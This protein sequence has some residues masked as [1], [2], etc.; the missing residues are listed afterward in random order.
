MCGIAGVL[1]EV[2]ARPPGN[3]ELRRMAM[4]IRHRGPDGFGSYVDDQVG[5]VHA[6]LAV[7]DVEGGAQPLSNEDGS[8]WI[9]FNG[10]IFNYLELRRE[11][12]ACGHRFRTRSDTEVIVHA[13]EEWGAQA[14]TKMNGQFAFALCDRR[15]HE[16]WLVRDRVGIAPLFF[17]RAAGAV[18][19]GSEVKAILASGLVLPA[20]ND[21]ALVEVFRYWSTPGPE[22]VFAGVQQVPP[23]CAVHFDD[24]LR[25]RQ[26]RYFSQRFDTSGPNSRLTIAEASEVLGHL[27]RDAVRIRLRADVPVGAYLSGGLDSS[28]V[29]QLVRQLDTSRLQTFSVR[30]ADARYDEGAAQERIARI[31]G[32]SHH[33]ILATAEILATELPN[34]IEHCET[35]LLRT[36]PIPMFVLSVLVRKLGMR[37]VLTGEGADEFLGGYDLFKEDGVR[38]FWARDPL[39]RTRP[40]LLTRI[41]PYIESS[42]KDGMWQAFFARG[43]TDVDDPF[44]SHRPRWET[45]GWTTRFISRDVRASLD[46][47]AAI[48]RLEAA[49]PEGWRES[50]ALERAQHIEIATFMSPYLLASQGDRALM[51]HGVEGRFPFLDPQVIEFVST[52]A[53]RHKLRGLHDKIVLRRLARQWLPDEI[54]SRPKWPYR[55]PIMQAFV[56]QSAPAYVRELMS[57]NALKSNPLLDSGAATALATRAFAQSHSMSEREEMA[58]VGVLTTQIWYRAFIDPGLCANGEHARVPATPEYASRVVAVD[59]RSS[60]SKN[61]AAPA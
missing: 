54:A 21:A 43:L 12:E 50:G 20:V 32:T 48:Q 60:C 56:G 36:A 41:H 42:G 49:L 17:A 15:K 53:P 24:R 5:L 51:S 14:W 10:E 2:G 7:L 29:A 8:L 23:G 45:T 3:E 39:S 37:V 52:L 31:L 26:V 44:Y 9:A 19:F 4:A 40:R 18:V 11:L 46:A 33:E 59:R 1:T 27:L 38:R 57:A 35:P 61:A 25:A 55:A 30:F 6:R 47:E 13:Y 28:I 22:T 34:V 16:T 58:L